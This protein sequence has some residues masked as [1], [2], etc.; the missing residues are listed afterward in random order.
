MVL[1]GLTSAL[2]NMQKFRGKEPLKP[3]P[4][5]MMTSKL[6]SWSGQIWCFQMMSSSN[7]GVKDVSYFIHT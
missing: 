3:Q 7:S 6:Q 1:V 5:Q 4:F 2:E